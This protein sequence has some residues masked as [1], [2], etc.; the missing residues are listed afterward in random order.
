MT[1]DELVAK[2]QEIRKDIGNKEVKI[3]VQNKGTEYKEV[4]IQT[5]I[6][7]YELAVIAPDKD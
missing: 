7:F 5:V 1:I 2:L 6:N 3:A 4:G